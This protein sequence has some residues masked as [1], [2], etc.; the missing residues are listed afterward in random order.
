AETPREHRAGVVA[1]RA[2]DHADAGQAREGG[3]PRA[4]R[5]ELG[6]IP[7]P[8]RLIGRVDR[9]RAAA[10]DDSIAPRRRKFGLEG[11]EDVEQ[12]DV[13]V[14]RELAKV[15]LGV[16]AE[17]AEVADEEEEAPGPCDARQ[18]LQRM[19]GAARRRRRR[20]GPETVLRDELE[21]RQRGAAAQTGTALLVRRVREHEAAEPVA[22]RDRAPRDE[23]GGLRR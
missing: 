6:V 20:R 7:R 10:D 13:A 15:A 19:L 2:V 4:V 11:V 3:E 14:A 8:E 23:R 12:E 1:R 22:V 16:G 5:L 18:P 9:D 17:T 21:E